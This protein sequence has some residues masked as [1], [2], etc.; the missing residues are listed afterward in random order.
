M[1]RS[2]ANTRATLAYRSAI[3]DAF[4]RYK[5]RR[6]EAWQ[7]CGKEFS[8][9]CRLEFARAWRLL[10][11]ELHKASVILEETRWAV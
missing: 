2:E 7:V 5:Q 10:T 6:A 9:K 1:T 4:A 8:D 11:W 3:A